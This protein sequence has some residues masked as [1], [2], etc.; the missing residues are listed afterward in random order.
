[1]SARERAEQRLIRIEQ[2][3]LPDRGVML[4]NVCERA[5]ETQADERDVYLFHYVYHLSWIIA[6]KNFN[7]N[8]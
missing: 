5:A 2:P 3:Q 6:H 1:M 8:W 7:G 4:V